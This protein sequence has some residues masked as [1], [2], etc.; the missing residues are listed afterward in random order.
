MFKIVCRETANESAPR[1]FISMINMEVLNITDGAAIVNGPI[2]SS[3]CSDRQSNLPALNLTGSPFFF[4]FGNVF[5][6]VGCNVRALLTGIGP[7]VV[8]CDSTCSA[9]YNQ[10]TLLYGQEINSLCADGNCCVASAPYRMQVFQPSLDAKN[11]SEDSSGCKLAFLTDQNKF[12]F[13]NMTNPQA[14]QGWRSVPVVLAWMMDYSIWRY[15][16]STMDCKYFLYESTVSNVSGY[17]CSCSN[18][19]EGNPYLGC[20][21]INECKDPNRHSCLGITKCVN[22]LGSY[23]CEVNKYWIVPILVVAIAGILSLLAGINLTFSF[24]LIM[25]LLLLSLEYCHCLLAFILHFPCNNA[26]VAAIAGILSL[27]AG[28][29]WL[30]KLARKRKHKELKRKFFKRNGGLLLQQQLSSNHVSVQKTKIFTSKELE[31][32]TDRFNENRILGQGGQGTVYKGMLEDGRIVAVKRSTIVGEEKLEEF[33]NEVVILSQI[34]HRNVVKLFGCCL[35]TEVPLLVYEFISNGNLFQYLHNFYQNEDFIL[36]WEMRLQIAIE[37][38][39]ALSYLHSA[40]SIPIFHRD[41]KSA[42]ILLDDK[43]RAKVSDFGSSRSVAI[44][45]T[46]LTTN[47]QGTFGYLDPEY[48]Q[49]SQLTDKSDVY[50][51]GVVLVEL[52]SGKKPIISSTSQERTSLAT[53]FIALMEENRLFDILDVQVKEGCLEEEI[54]A[55]ANRAKRCLNMSR[56]HRPPMKE[57]SAELE[58]IGLLQRKSNVQQKEEETS[59]NAMVERLCNWDAVPISATCDFDNARSVQ[60]TDAEPLITY[61]TL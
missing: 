28:I 4:S 14:L 11:G 41:I 48:F 59:Q 18:G 33:I 31:R 19:Y 2:M 49:S 13:L 12:S 21:D 32:A 52:L 35:E 20:A 26:V 50:S 7:Q 30:Y 54:M 23:K 40:A 36:S 46:H 15:D 61:N 58:R 1:A 43:C 42:N 10:K 60:S 47:V 5:T 57:V 34:N 16:N 3:N 38:A 17:E 9:D 25:Q 55:V 22:T 39:G 29:S 51:F 56:K 8:G 53:H 37:V 24:L 45:Q 44:D 6:A 27:L